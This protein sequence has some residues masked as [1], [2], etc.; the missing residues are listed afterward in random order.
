M[1]KDIHGH[2]NDS[3]KLFET[4]DEKSQR[5]IKSYL[6]NKQKNQVKSKWTIR[7]RVESQ[8]E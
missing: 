8:V 4:Y 2:L 7:P 6:F 5:R 1:T 3:L